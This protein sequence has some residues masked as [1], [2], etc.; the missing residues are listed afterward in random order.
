MLLCLELRSNEKDDAFK[1]A[2][3]EYQRRLMRIRHQSPL[4]KSSDRSEARGF[5]GVQ[6]VKARSGDSMKGE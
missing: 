6:T 3:R 1:K 4:I 2:N 5:S